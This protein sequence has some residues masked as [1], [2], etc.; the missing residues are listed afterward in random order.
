[1]VVATNSTRTKVLS[2]FYHLSGIF[3]VALVA[4]PQVASQYHFNENPHTTITNDTVSHYVIMVIFVLLA[5]GSIRKT[6][7]SVGWYILPPKWQ[8]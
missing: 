7:P 6:V 2:L 8:K 5:T 4:K 3:F 1:M